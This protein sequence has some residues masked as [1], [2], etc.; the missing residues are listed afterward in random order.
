MLI[1]YNYIYIYREE[2]GGASAVKDASINAAGTCDLR[3]WE[4]TSTNVII[5]TFQFS[6]LT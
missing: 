6:T 5:N 4:G 3:E 1:E 2:E